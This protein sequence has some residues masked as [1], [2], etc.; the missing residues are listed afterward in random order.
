MFKPSQILPLITAVILFVPAISN[1]EESEEYKQPAKKQVTEI[2]YGSGLMTKNEID[3]YRTKLRS[4]KT[5]AERKAYD[6]EHKR[7]MQER[8]FQNS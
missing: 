5:E 7:E 3:E 6:L 2:I 4:L 8:A 1:A